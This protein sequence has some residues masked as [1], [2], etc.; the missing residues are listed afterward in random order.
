M[1]VRSL[2]VVVLVFSAHTLLAQTADLRLTRIETDTGAPSGAAAVIANFHNYGPSSADDFQITISLPEGT[3]YL[4]SD[5]QAPLRCTPPP[6]GSRGT[7]TCTA[8]TLSNGDGGDVEIIA[9]IDPGVAPGTVLSFPITMT[10]S[11]A[12]QPSQYATATLTVAA[13]TA[14]VISA[15]AP[16]AVTAG[17]AFVT[18]ITLTNSGPA[19]AIGGINIISSSPL[20]VQQ[21]TG[22]DGWSCSRSCFM[23][24][25]PPGKA[26]FTVTSLVPGT[27]PLPS[28]TQKIFVTSLN[29]PDQS[30]DTVFLTTAV[31][32]TPQTTLQAALEGTPENFYSGDTVTYTE[33][34]TNTG[35]S[36]AY[37]VH[38]GMVLNGNAATTTC[39]FITATGCTFPSVA[40]GA[41]QTITATVRIFESPGSQVTQSAFTSAFN[42]PAGN[43]TLTTTLNQTPPPTRR[44]SARH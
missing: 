27:F 15:N 21:M 8:K 41:T 3:T 20:E 43:A 2:V 19:D 12:L 6:S 23:S 33:R 31:T 4:D 35:K 22:P 24:T 44:R 25:F 16:T 40:A 9:R 18:N 38:M 39:G 37:D 1:S 14:L 13:P 42:A 5:A 26:K 32:P 30:D 34:V 11:T 17:D 10:S 7:L 36:T 29:D 28:I